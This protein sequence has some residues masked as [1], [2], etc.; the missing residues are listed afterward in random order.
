[1]FTDNCL[2]GYCPPGQPCFPSGVYMALTEYYCENGI[3][4]STTHICPSGYTCQDGACKAPSITVTSPSGAVTLLEGSDYVI[5]WDASNIPSDAKFYI[6]LFRSDGANTS[7]VQNLPATQREYLWKVTTSGNWGMGYN[8]KPSLLAKIF[9]IKKVK[10]ESY[11]YQIMVSTTWGTFGSNYYGNAYNKSDWFYIVPL[12]P[13]TTIPSYGKCTDGSV[14]GWCGDKCTKITAGMDCPQ[15]APPPGTNCT[16]INNTCTVQYSSSTL[17][18][19]LN[20]LTASLMSLMELL[21][22]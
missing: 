7:I 17:M 20:K 2:N 9:N 13:V 19:T 8:D 3:I 10:A 16:C 21:K 4:N 22:H 12:I 5:K 1:M 15:V 14:C 6:T 11:S 18:D